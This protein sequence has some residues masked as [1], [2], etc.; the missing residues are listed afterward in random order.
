VNEVIESAGRD[1]ELGEYNQRQLGHITDL[2][3]FVNLPLESSRREIRQHL[4][5]S[6]RPPTHDRL[7]PLARRFSYCVVSID[8]VDSP[9]RAR[10]SSCE[11]GSAIAYQGVITESIS[12]MDSPHSCSQD[13]VAT[14]IRATNS[15]SD[16][17]DAALRKVLADLPGEKKRREIWK[18]LMGEDAAEGV[19]LGGIAKGT[20]NFSGSDL[21]RASSP[22]LRI[23]SKMITSDRLIC[24]CCLGCSQ[25]ECNSVLENYRGIK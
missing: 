22:F 13:R 3:K 5:A 25:G 15:L 2:R 7:F 19:D 21:K 9:F 8:E 12:E 20:G 23:T 16:F 14:T 18:I 24:C 4:R 10:M 17:D 11:T 6:A 1:P